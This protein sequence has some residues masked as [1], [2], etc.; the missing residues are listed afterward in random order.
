M[1]KK[2]TDEEEQKKKSIEEELKQ[3]Q[4]AEAKIQEEN[5]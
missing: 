4:E 5:K 2:K 3:I 1:K